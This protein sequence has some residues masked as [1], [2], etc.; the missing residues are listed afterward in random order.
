[1]KMRKFEDRKIIKKIQDHKMHQ[2]CYI[3]HVGG[4]MVDNGWVVQE[5]CGMPWELGIGAVQPAGVVN[6]LTSHV[7]LCNACG[8]HIVI[9][10]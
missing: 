9:V 2:N 5:H 6:P 4:S 1:M 10:A 3:F 8:M 7:M